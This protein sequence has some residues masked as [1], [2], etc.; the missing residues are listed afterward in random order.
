MPASFDRTPRTGRVGTLLAGGAGAAVSISTSHGRIAVRTTAGG[1]TPLVLL[2]G[3]SSSMAEFA[4][5]LASRLG[6]DRAL[7]ALDLPGHGGS[8]AA[9]DP[10]HSYTLDGY[11]DAVVEVLEHLGIEE[12]GV[13]GRSLGARVGLRMAEAYPGL[14]GLA[15]LGDDAGARHLGRDPPPAAG[16]PAASPRIVSRADERCRRVA[17]AD[18]PPAA[19]ELAAAGLA[20]GGDRPFVE[21]PAEPDRLRAELRAFLHRVDLVAPGLALGLCLAG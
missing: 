3:A 6:R 14:A 20:V 12:V 13:L 16:A 1:G 2:H 10:G 7:V 17:G 18:R 9:R 5:L 19:A 15:V 11:A 21:L 8:G 4:P